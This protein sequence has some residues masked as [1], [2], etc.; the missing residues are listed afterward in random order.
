M[1]PGL[2]IGIVGGGIGGLA[3]AIAL[4]RKGVAAYVYERANDLTEVGAGL[5]LWPNATWLLQQWGLLDEAIARGSILHSV[6]LR[7]WS[8]SLLT[9]ST[10]ISKQPTP[11][12]CMHR[13][14]LLSLLRTAIPL[15]HIH[16]GRQFER[17]DLKGDKPV[18]HFQNG[19]EV[20][21][22]W[23]GADG[24]NSTVRTQLHG[25]QAP[26]YRGYQAYRGVSSS[27]N[28]SFHEKAF[29]SW[30][31]GKRFGACPIGH[32]RIYWYAAIT[33]TAGNLGPPSTWK[34]RLIQKY[35]NWH[36]PI[37]D[38]ISSTSENAILGH[39]VCDREPLFEWG[40]GSVT[41]L[42]DAAHPMTPDLGQGACMAMEDADSLSDCLSQDL[43]LVDSL[44]TFEYFRY[45][46]TRMMMLDSRRL[47]SMGQWSNPFA[48]LLR[49]LWLTLL[50][51]S[52]LDRRYA[53]YFD[54]GE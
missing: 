19:P 27:S 32:G 12:L 46:R 43:P 10:T 38:L 5:T 37:P 22:A 24:L 52:I 26:I 34:N 40:R 14:E 3:T 7:K 25:R 11:A 36:K 18:A 4:G 13:A 17:F 6:E 47:G 45:D 2:R 35:S 8:G 39:E 21:D 49:T 28:L 9:A 30:G 41:L 1:N 20:A 50:P 54:Y 31:Y 16:L 44:R 29:E 23:I 53:T 48:V 15:D 51:K 42:G 33:A